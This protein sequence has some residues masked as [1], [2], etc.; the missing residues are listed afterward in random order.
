M[1]DG[2]VVARPGPF[3]SPSFF[4]PHAG[5]YTR[6]QCRDETDAVIGALSPRCLKLV[7][8]TSK[9]EFVDALEAAESSGRRYKP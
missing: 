5:S 2:Q 1:H 3:G 9:T 7:D 6:P 4:R 8:M